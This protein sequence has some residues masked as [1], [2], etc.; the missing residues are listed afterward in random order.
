MSGA[1]S[2]AR[3]ISGT[4]SE[5]SRAL[6]LFDVAAPVPLAFAFGALLAPSAARSLLEAAERIEADTRNVTGAA[7]VASEIRR[8]KRILLFLNANRGLCN[9]T[10]DS[11]G[12]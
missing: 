9:F 3:F 5:A 6:V 10:E 1:E 8:T 11:F 7:K 12:G 4:P 2:G